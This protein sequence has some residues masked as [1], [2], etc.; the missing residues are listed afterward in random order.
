MGSSQIQADEENKIQARGGQCGEKVKGENKIK[1][2]LTIIISSVFI[3]N[4]RLLKLLPEG[5]VLLVIAS[6]FRGFGIVFNEPGEE[7][8]IVDLLAEHLFMASGVM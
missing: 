3:F 6:F 8:R 5:F 4:S 1:K 7:F 2:I